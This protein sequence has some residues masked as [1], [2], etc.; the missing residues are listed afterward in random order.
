M[1]QNKEK[2]A[3]APEASKKSTVKAE[4]LIAA[5]GTAT[6]SLLIWLISQVMAMGATVQKLSATQNV[7]VDEDVLR[8][9]GMLCFELMH[10]L[11]NILCSDMLKIL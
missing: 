4:S 3:P 1:Q 8:P 10:I 2:P 7:L 11:L 6:G 5:G 9:A